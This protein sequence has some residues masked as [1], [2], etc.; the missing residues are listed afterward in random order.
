MEISAELKGRESV[1][2]E[3]SLGRIV[4]LKMVLG[5][6]LGKTF[7]PHW[8]LEDF[9]DPSPVHFLGSRYKA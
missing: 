6:F 1:A 4:F 2:M 3:S 9:L 5:Y 8:P 7:R